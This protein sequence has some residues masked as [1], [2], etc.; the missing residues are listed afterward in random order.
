M[1]R[2]ANRILSSAI[3]LTA[4]SLVLYI[5]RHNLRSAVGRAFCILLIFVMVVYLG[6]A[7]I[8]EVS[9]LESKLTWLRFQWLGIAFVPAAYLHFS[10]ALLNTTNSD[11]KAI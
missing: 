3:L 6:D 1:L 9:S 11:P 8:L 10:D 5:L 7:V 2:V 4:F